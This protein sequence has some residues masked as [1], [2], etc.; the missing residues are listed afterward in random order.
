MKS[1]L[2][3][4]FRLDIYRRMLP[5]ARPFVAPMM[6]VMLFTFLQV[7][8]GVLDPWPMKIL[9]DNGLSG[10]PLSGPFGS[11]VPFLN[12]HTG[13]EVVIFAVVLALLLRV[14][15][16]VVGITS[17]YIKTRVNDSMRLNFQADM[18]NHLQRLSFSYH[19]QTT[20]GDSMYRLNNDTDFITTLIW[21]NLR[22]FITAIGTLVAMFWIVLQLDSTLALLSLAAAP[23]L[24]TAAVFY[25]RYFKE[26]IK[27]VLS[28]ESRPQTVMQEVLSSLRVVK[29]FGMEEREQRRFEEAS[30]KAVR[31]RWRLTLLQSIYSSSLGFFTLLLRSFI[32]LVGGLHVLDGKLTVGELLVIVAYVSNIHGPLE[33]TSSTLT[34]MQLSLASGERVL[35]VLNV[36][37]EVQDRPGALTLDRVQG[38][39]R[40]EDVSFGYYPTRPVLHDISVLA[41]PDSVTAIVGPTGAGKTTLSNLI[42]RFYDPMSGRVTL[43]GHDL[44]DLTV[45]TLRDNIALVIQ[46]PILFGGSIRDNI[47]YGRPEAGM[48]EIIGAAQAAN[49]HDFISALPEGYDTDVGGRGVRLSGGERQR[50]AIARAFLKD[51]PVLILDEPTSSVDSRTELVILNALDRLMVGRTTFII[52]HRLSTIRRADTVLVMEHGRI[53]ERGTHAGLLRENGLYAQLYHIQS[54]ALRE[55]EED[56]PSTTVAEW[57]LDGRTGVAHEEIVAAAMAA[58]ADGV[59]DSLPQ[60]YD[61]VIGAGGVRLDSQQRQALALARTMLAEVVE[62]RSPLRS[63]GVGLP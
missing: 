59:I 12:G 14:V 47:A 23:V 35:D 17:D 43:D 57:I 24:Y 40:L 13:R 53:I 36:E 45:K 56:E 18:F 21:G 52:A 42:A 10:K 4:Y 55:T 1:K 31:A 15:G 34:D 30:W 54:A 37:P 8:L 49:A 2:N 33:D 25:G 9:V 32:L 60:G 61:T 39:I 11:I 58:N 44:R 62:R 7:G 28:M 5:Y 19:D 29:A 51:A 26:R 22:H 16:E 63:P 20:V 41:A 46:E 50:V 3:G 27:E 48:E 38:E 6:A